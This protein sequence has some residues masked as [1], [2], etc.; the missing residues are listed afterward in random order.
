MQE[1]TLCSKKVHHQT[2]GGNHVKS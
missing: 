1:C 2:H